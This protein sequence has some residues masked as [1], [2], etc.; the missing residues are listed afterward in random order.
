MAELGKEKSNPIKDATKKSITPS[1][2]G[3]KK[4]E[5]V[6]N[7]TAAR[8]S[9]SSYEKKAEGSNDY[10]EKDSVEQSRAAEESP[11]NTFE[12]AVGGKGNGEAKGLLKKGGPLIAILLSIFGIGAGMFGAQGLLPFSLAEQL[13]TKFD[14]LSTS[15]ELRSTTFLRYQLSNGNI[16]NSIAQKV[17]GGTKFK[18]SNKQKTKLKTQGIEIAEVDVNGKKT[19]VMVFD[20]GSPTRKIVT[21]DAN[22]AEKIKTSG[23]TEIDV[24][25]TKFKINVDDTMDFATK[26]ET[27]ADF[28]NGYTKSSRTWR[29]AIGAWFDQIAV[30]FLQSN[31]ITRNSFKNFQERVEGEAAGNRKA[32]ADEIMNNKDIDVSSDSKQNNTMIEVEEDGQK[33]SKNVTYD[34]DINEYY[35]IKEIQTAEGDSVFEKVVISDNGKIKGEYKNKIL[36][37]PIIENGIKYKINNRFDVE[38]AKAKLSDLQAKT[39]GKISGV[40]SAAVNVACT[41]FSLVGVVELTIAAQE[42]LQVLQVANSYLEAIDKAKAGDGTD[43]PVNEYANNLTQGTILKTIEVDGEINDKDI[44]S[45]SSYNVM[46]VSVRD[47]ETSAMQSSGIVSLYSDGQINPNDPSVKNFTIGDRFSSIASRI[48]VSAQSFMGCATA[49]IAA[50]LADI[51]IDVTNIVAC[52]AS[53]G[54]GCVVALIEEA[55]GTMVGSVAI[56]GAVSI[57]TKMMIPFF[58][59]T[60][61]RDLVSNIAG[62]DLGNALVSGAHIYQSSNHKSG[63]GSLASAQKYI[64]YNAERKKV[65][66]EYARYQ[67]ETLNPFD[68]SS[69][70]TFF[71]SLA[72]QM[73][74]IG[75]TVS[76]SNN[77]IST[78]SN[79]VSNSI[80]A[81]LPTASAIATEADLLENYEVICPSLASINA[82]GDAFCNPYIISDLST[83]NED[84][85]KIVVEVA[86]TGALN[87]DGEIVE[88]SD[89]EKYILYC[90]DRSSAFGVADTN[91]ANAFSHD[92]ETGNN[93]INTVTNAALGAIPVI[94]DLI[95][96][97]SNTD[98]LNNIGWIT[99]SSCVATDSNDSEWNSKMRVYQRYVEDQR[100]MENMDDKYES[101]VVAFKDKYYEENPL[102]NSYEG[103][104]ARYSGLE[105]EDV[106]AVITYMTYQSYLADYN[107]GTRCVF[108][109]KEYKKKIEFDKTINSNLE[110]VLLSNIF[111]SSLLSRNQYLITA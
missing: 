9:F 4:D 68:A 59:T 58:I 49:K 50:A 51:A 29:G 106:V 42:T 80:V 7:S 104:L 13:K 87:S 110:A 54:I 96:V 2:F 109:E 105:K 108:G 21:S 28:R 14:S 100:L 98:E 39:K 47:V 34:S 60:F 81:L 10:D 85:E 35:Y 90:N 6:T 102:D 25:G 69:Q 78:V 52:A 30:R 19:K 75:T 33:I 62:E 77:I 12:N 99:G 61:S 1:F 76:S 3:T 8:D 65:Q 103:I 5:K 22:I 27:S 72:K 17:F 86:S 18:V 48:G 83:I 70:Y 73:I 15:M 88:G 91:I 16:Q 40:T 24:E 36:L 74:T 45:D 97:F 11:E 56:A 53:F 20:D 84:P 92:V 93:S 23:L 79:M 95:D 37:T 71:G 67:R 107:P 41:V 55:G 111:N 43:S 63:G 64:A 94:G 31:N 101:A 66:D 57:A 82:V 46:E 38:Q 26:F 32:M 44:D 89:L